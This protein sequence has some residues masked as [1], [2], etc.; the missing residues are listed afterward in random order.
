MVTSHA[1]QAP[2]KAA[3]IVRQVYFQLG[4]DIPLHRRPHTDIGNAQMNLPVDLGADG[5]DS[6]KRCIA[7]FKLDICGRRSQLAA[8]FLPVHNTPS[9]AEWSAKQPL[10]Q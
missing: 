3:L 9:E 2:V 4:L 10:R 1:Q 7:A 5:K 8:E 6:R